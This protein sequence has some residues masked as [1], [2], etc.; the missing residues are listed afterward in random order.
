MD[1]AEIDF[2]KLIEL[3]RLDAEI[4]HAALFLENI[5]RLLDEI[6]K[7]IEAGSLAVAEARENLARNQKSR[8]EL[9]SQVKDAKVQITRFKRQLNEVKTN[10]EYTALLHE[11]GE[12]QQT[13]DQMEERII[14]EMLAADDIE[15]EIRAALHK[16]SQDE[17]TLRRDKDV[18]VL[19]RREMEEKHRRLTLDKAALLP[20]VPPEQARLYASIAAKK[21][22][23]ALSP[24]KGDF[25]AMCHMRIR[26]QMINEIRQ[27]R[28]IMLCENCGRILY[29]PAKPEGQAEEPIG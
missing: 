1:T 26:P 17:E 10:R 25:C 23:T 24:V 5:P 14:S 11:I 15:E 18:L 19:K 22:G 27:R 21:A 13:V 16:Q 4:R 8:R 3:Q 28:E 6:D 2:D 9:E 7:K 12:V 20:Q 29:W